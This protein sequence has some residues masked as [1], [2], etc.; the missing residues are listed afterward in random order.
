M[1]KL[2]NN[3]WTQYIYKTV[4]ID[5]MQ[6]VNNSTYLNEIP[7]IKIAVKSVR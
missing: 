4:N 2:K 6:I 7:F 5:K 3:G 1:L